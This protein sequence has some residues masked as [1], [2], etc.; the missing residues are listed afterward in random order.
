M[1]HISFAESTLKTRI[2][3]QIFKITGE[4]SCRAF[5]NSE[6]PPPCPADSEKLQEDSFGL[7]GVMICLDTS[8]LQY[9][10]LHKFNYIL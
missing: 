4:E 7:S 10:V 1:F 8:F 5:Q 9:K 3:R 6:Q 2:L